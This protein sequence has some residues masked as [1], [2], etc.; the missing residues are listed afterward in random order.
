MSVN[1]SRRLPIWLRIIVFVVLVGLLVLFTF[2]GDSHG[3][4]DVS[5][6]LTA[7][8]IVLI[9]VYAFAIEGGFGYMEIICP[10]LLV[11]YCFV[12]PLWHTED[13][14]TT[15][16]VGEGAA[17]VGSALM[18][19]FMGIF[20]G[21]K[22]LYHDYI[23]IFDFISFAVLPIAFAIGWA[24]IPYDAAKGFAIV[25]L[26]GGAVNYFMP[27]LWRGPRGRSSSSRNNSGGG[28]KRPKINSYQLQQIASSVAT[29]H[30]SI[31]FSNVSGKKVY[32]RYTGGSNAVEKKRAFDSYV[33]SLQS[34]LYDY[35][36][37][38]VEIY[39][40]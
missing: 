39:C 12:I 15:M 17:V 4:T 11:V 23:K 13:Q 24:K 26:I 21:V 14:V 1:L 8:A 9:A 2:V 37:S 31:S 7:V 5:N 29:S 18:C 3:D 16:N 40:Q 28:T 38:D 6:L 27:F 22:K 36:A 10:V 20:G 34:S 19:I 30:P 32:V 25:S 35:D 33:S